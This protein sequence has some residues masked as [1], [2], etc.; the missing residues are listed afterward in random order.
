MNMPWWINGNRIVGKVKDSAFLAAYGKLHDA[1]LDPTS[2]SVLA[3][4]VVHHDSE[5]VFSFLRRNAD[6]KLARMAHAIGLG[7]DYWDRG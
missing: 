4:E 3:S 6:E 1:G 5:R 2:A 7:S